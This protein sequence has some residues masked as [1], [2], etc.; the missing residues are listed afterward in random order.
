M[1]AMSFNSSFS[2]DGWCFLIPRLRNESS[3]TYYSVT[4]AACVITAFLAPITVVAN[5]VVLAA[6]WMN[7]SLRTPSYVLLAGLAAT[8]FCTGLLSQPFSVIY[9]LAEMARN[10]K[11]YCIAGLVT[12]S[13]AL[14]FSSLTVI[15]ITMIA[16]E[17][18]L[19]MSRRSVLTVRRVIVLYITFG[20]LPI[21]GVAARMYSLYYQDK[22]FRSVIT[23]YSLAAALCVLL[24]AFA[25]FKVFQIIRRHQNQVQPNENAIT[26]KKYQKSVITILYILAIFVLSY[27]PYLCIFFVFH[28][29][30]QND[31]KTAAALNAC[32]A[33]VFSS[34]L[35]NPLL[36]YWRMKE[37]RDGVKSVIRK[38]FCKQSDEE[39]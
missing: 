11:L 18:W 23:F 16:V 30:S 39:S 21:L 5:G 26:M 22:I 12:E 32:A 19:H 28:F 24:T 27:A 9:K 29:S 33:V 17:R 7:P 14:Y 2:S 31:D 3:S 15:V 36:Y 8:D 1:Q 37:I 4:L 34:S 25:Y 38:L 20:V 13:A 6:I 35:F 10:R